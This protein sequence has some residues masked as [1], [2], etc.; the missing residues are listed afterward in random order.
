MD[1]IGVL[2][3]VSGSGVEMIFLSTGP[4]ILLPSGSTVDINGTSGILFSYILSV[5]CVL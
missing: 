2:Q 4:H 5:C 1:W 3:P